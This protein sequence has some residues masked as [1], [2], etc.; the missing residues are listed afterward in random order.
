MTQQPDRYQELQQQI[1]EL[2][3]ETERKI[4][5]LLDESI[6][7]NDRIDRLTDRI[8]RIGDRIDR[9]TDRMDRVTVT[10]NRL[11]TEAATDRAIIRGIQAENSRILNYLFGQQRGNGSE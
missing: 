6:A 1:A 10:V 4:N 11:A 3:L 5:I 7:S 2:Q 9:L 8:E